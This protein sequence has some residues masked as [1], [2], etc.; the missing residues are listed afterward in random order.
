MIVRP[1]GIEDAE[2]A[3]EALRRSI[4][5]LCVADHNNLEKWLSKKTPDHVR[6]WIENPDTRIFVATEGAKIVAVGAVTTRGEILLNYV[7]PEARLRGASTARLNQ[8]EAKAAA[9][10]NKICVL[11][12]TAT[13]RDFYHAAG[14]RPD[15]SVPVHS[16][17]GLGER[18]TKSIQ[19]S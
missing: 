11:T 7:S 19:G 12:S 13:A 16:R 18:M 2:E 1:I 10:G 3:R 5:E 17:T 14:Y 6:S 4:S 9:L 15:D 8:L